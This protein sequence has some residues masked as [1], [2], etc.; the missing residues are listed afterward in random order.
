MSPSSPPSSLRRRGSKA[1]SASPKFIVCTD[2]GLSSVANRAHNSKGSLQFVTTVCLRGQRK[3]VKDWVRGPKG[4]SCTGE[5]GTFD[6]DQVRKAAVDPLTPEK[7][8]RALF[9]RTF[10]KTMWTS[11]KD[12]ATGEELG[13]NLIVTFSLRYRAYQS[14]IRKAQVERARRACEDGTAKRQRKGPK[15]PMRFVSSTSVNEEG[16]VAERCILSVDDRKVK[17]EASWDGFYGLATSLDDEDVLGIVKLA[18]GRWQVEEC[19]RIMKGEFR[20]RPVFL[21]RRD[22]IEAHFLTCFLAL[23][24]Y[25]I[26]EKRLDGRFSCPEIVD[27]LRGMQ[28]EEVTGEGW[29]PLYMRTEVT[30]ALHDAFGFRTDFEIVPVRQMNK[31]VRKT[32]RKGPITTKKEAG[33]DIK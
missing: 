24:I 18:A 25:R 5:A 9:A 10:Y 11:L 22:R 8:R 1:S 12:P 16:E 6:L 14:S 28:M 32:H 20:A 19:F 31:I 21:S 27:T 33:K 23:L 17:E 3:E 4:W 2:A 15:D 30:D 29:R 26:L 13:Q 7:T